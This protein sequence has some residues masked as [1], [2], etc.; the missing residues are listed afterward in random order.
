MCLLRANVREAQ[1]AQAPLECHPKIGVWRINKHVKKDLIKRYR[2]TKVKLHN[3]LGVLEQLK[4][5]RA[6][7][8]WNTHLDS[9]LK[10]WEE[11]KDNCC[12]TPG[13]TYIKGD[14]G[15][16][17]DSSSDSG[18]TKDTPSQANTT[19]PAPQPPSHPPLSLSCLKRQRT[20]SDPE[21]DPRPPKKVC[22]DDTV[23]VLSGGLAYTHTSSTRTHNPSTAYRRTI[24]RKSRHYKP[25]TWAPAHPN[26]YVDTSGSRTSAQV[27]ESLQ[28][29]IAIEEK[30]EMKDFQECE[31]CLDL[32]VEPAV[33]CDECLA[34]QW[35]REREAEWQKLENEREKRE[36][37]M[38]WKARREVK[39]QAREK[40]NKQRKREKPWLPRWI[41]A[42]TAPVSA[43]PVS[44]E[45]SSADSSPEESQTP[46]PAS[47]Q[48]G[49]FVYDHEPSLSR[50]IGEEA[51]LV[52][53][54]EPVPE[55]EPV[56]A[57]EQ[58][59]SSQPSSEPSS[60]EQ[61]QT[62]TS[63]P[64]RIGDFVYDDTRTDN[65]ERYLQ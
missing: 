39:R 31:G 11:V 57:P 52:P 8:S 5:E 13:Y 37:E 18:L 14:N 2:H 3:A 63:T 43:Q 4:R 65:L 62:P 34:L 49:N 55:P 56:P 12:Q 59:A 46:S 50:E 41:G 28:A 9:A 36:R 64:L 15:S 26:A 17:Y 33:Y 42:E 48:I 19:S 7:E 61:S 24:K 27:I 30:G 22:M 1:D 45:L 53:V 60:S 20:S 58:P 44:S 32:V 51:A 16:D 21:E 29:N 54:P 10:F 40:A 23:T 25:S 35:H 47:A 38:A 6:E